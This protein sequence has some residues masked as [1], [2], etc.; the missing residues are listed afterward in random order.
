M[1][2]APSTMELMTAHAM[3]RA[4]EALARTQHGAF[5]IRQAQQL[6]ASPGMIRRRRDNGAWQQ[7]SRTVWTLPA[8]P[9]TWHRQVMAAVLSLDR[10]AVSGLAAAHLHGLDGFRPVRPELTVPRGGSRRSPFARVHQSDRARL[11]RRGPFPVVTIEQTLCDSAGR[12]S[13]CHLSTAVEAAII[14]GRTSGDAVLARAFALWPRPPGGSIGLIE[15]A[16]ELSRTD[17]VPM[18]VLEAALFRVLGDP[19]I[20]PWEAQATPNW[21]PSSTERLDVLISRW[22]LTVEADGRR[23]HTGRADF[24]NDRRRDHV[25]LVHDH[26][27]LRFTNQQLTHEPEYVLSVLLAVGAHSRRNAG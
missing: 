20:P 13:P 7:L 15:V 3:D 5:N 9:P 2:L 4:I 24:E 25:A 19:R 26:R 10:S 17:H 21:W 1:S 16:A 12:L 8:A 14:D 6:G 23:W 18:S 22:R 27:T 11:T